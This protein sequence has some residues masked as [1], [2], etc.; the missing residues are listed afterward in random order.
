MGGCEDKDAVAG[1]ASHDGGGIDPRAAISD[2]AILGA[3]CTVGAFAVIGPDV[4]L[5]AGNWVG[6]HAVV[7]GPTAMGDANEIHSFAVIGGSPQDLRHRGEPTR[8]EVGSRNTFREHVT[9]SRGTVHGGG[10]TTI[11][12]D[13][14]IMA[15]CH[16]AHDTRVGNRIVMANS[17]TLAG[18]AEVEDFAVFGGLVGVGPFVRIGESSMLAA[19]SM[20]ERDVPPFCIAAGDRATLR[21]VNRVG[22]R[23]RGFSDDAK[24]QIKRAFKLLKDK[25]TPIAAVVAALET[26]AALTPEARRMIEFLRSVRRG[27]LR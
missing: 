15:G 1:T 17:A 3:G 4:V 14:L 21:A 13:N 18:H 20:I 9:V 16:I 22:L 24:T 19:G 2:G 7:L 27:A 23:R 5:G 10:A 26:E 8:L 6:A 12:D 11:G 25:G